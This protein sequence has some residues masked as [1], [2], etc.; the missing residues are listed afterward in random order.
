[1][2]T[3]ATLI[4]HPDANQVTLTN[5]MGFPDSRRV[6]VAAQGGGALHQYPLLLHDAGAYL[7]ELREVY[8][9]LDGVAPNRGHHLV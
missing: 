8:G 3:I 1:M 7:Q 4:L 2:T 5:T 9:V 6:E